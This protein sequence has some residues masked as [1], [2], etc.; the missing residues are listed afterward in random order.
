MAALLDIG[1]HGIM[2]GLL[3]LI[4]ISLSLMS[5]VDQ[6]LPWFVLRGIKA[7]PTENITFAIKNTNGSG[8]RFL[9]SWVSEIIK[10]VNNLVN[11]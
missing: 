7:L 10:L 5:G 11:K 8:Q 2:S 9:D 4:T 1:F 6:K 3:P